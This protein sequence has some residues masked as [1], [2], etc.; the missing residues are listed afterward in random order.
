[1]DYQ[2]R[3]I[4]YLCELHHP[5][6]PL[7]PGRSRSST[8]RC[9]SRGIPLVE[10]RRHPGRS[11]PLELRSRSREPSSLAAFLVDRIQFREELGSMTYEEFGN[12]IRCVAEQAAER[13][14][15]Q[16]FTGQ[17][18]TIRCLINPRTFR[19]SRA[20]LRQGMFR[21]GVETEVLGRDPQL[22]GLRLVFPPGNESPDA[23]SLR[24]ESYNRDPQLALPR[25][26]GDVRAL[27]TGRSLTQIEENVRST[28]VF[29]ARARHRFRGTLRRPPG[30]L[31]SVRMKRGGGRRIGM[32]PLESPCLRSAILAGLVL[33]P[34]CGERPGGSVHAGSRR[35]RG[36]RAADRR[37]RVH[38]ARRSRSGSSASPRSS[39]TRARRSS[40]A[41]R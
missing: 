36:R 16:M 31:S 3:T 24:I 29:P 14:G 7:I 27:I 34:A 15:I 33:V 19:D 4:A 28:Y 10:L 25:E 20:F 5:R 26:P 23:F 6:S 21:F 11:R 37:P 30:S 22:Y 41:C 40:C 18:V 39:R 17:Q 8:T 2:Q 1:M 13:R 9:T 38:H 12:R 32:G 35:P